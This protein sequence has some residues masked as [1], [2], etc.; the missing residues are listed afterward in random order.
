[1]N[2]RPNARSPATGT[3]LE[4]HLPFP[5][6]TA[7]LIIEEV[8]LQRPGERAC[9]GLRPQ[10]HIHPEE[11]SLF[12][13][14]GQ[15]LHDTFPQRVEKLV[16]RR[17][18]VRTCSFFAVHKQQIHIRT[19][20]QFIPPELA[21]ADHGEACLRKSPQLLAHLVEGHANHRINHRIRQNRQL[22]R[23]APEIGEP[24]RILDTDA[25]KLTPEHSPDGIKPPLRSSKCAENPLD[26]LRQRAGGHRF[27]QHRRGGQP[28]EEG[29]ITDQDI[30]KI[31]RVAEDGHQ[32]IQQQGI[33][34]QIGAQRC[35][36]YGDFQI[37]EEVRERHIRVRTGTQCRRE[38]AGEIL[39]GKP[40]ARGD[41]LL[42]DRAQ[43]SLS[44]A[45]VGEEIRGKIVR[46]HD[47]KVQK[48]AIREKAVVL[49][50]PRDVAIFPQDFPA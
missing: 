10:A 30:R 18:A 38:H 20:V 31:A 26:F 46:G 23:H 28:P 17:P 47:C 34:Q 36:T 48:N 33:L 2:R 22:T 11:M 43:M 25:Q 3:G 39:E 7:G 49:L 15:M 8:T 37:A 41:E 45:R 21:Q 42:M 40:A 6:F 14:A 27:M 13:A 9:P 29:G 5:E 1:M 32:D 12:A 35:G 16:K 19:V 4:Q 24:E 44:A 50:F